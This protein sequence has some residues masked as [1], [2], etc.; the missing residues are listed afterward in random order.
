MVEHCVLNAI[1]RGKP[2]INTLDYKL[3]K[4]S[5]YEREILFRTV[6]DQLAFKKI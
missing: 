5:D 4:H 1:E 3:A 2:L 6:G